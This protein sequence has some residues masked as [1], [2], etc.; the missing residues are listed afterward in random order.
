[1]RNKRKKKCAAC[2]KADTE[3][4]MTRGQTLKYHMSTYVTPKI[5]DFYNMILL[6]IVLLLASMSDS[7]V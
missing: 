7:D 4:N 1:M 6:Y 2:K 3:A 5:S